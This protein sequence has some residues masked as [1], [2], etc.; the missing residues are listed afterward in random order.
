MR[1]LFPSLLVSSAVSVAAAAVSNLSW[2][3]LPPL[4]AA[5]GQAR[6]AGV[7][8]PFVGVHRDALIVA[9]GANF[10]DKM[11]WEGGAKVWWDD[12][13]ILEKT[14][15]GPLRWV[16]DKTFKLPRPIAYGVSVNV[17]GLL[18]SAP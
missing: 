15:D 8:S 9:G 12:I 13:W 11:P 14:T 1:S 3:E 5:P 10:P 4:P 17:P 18:G 16:A 7:A 2:D 6:Q